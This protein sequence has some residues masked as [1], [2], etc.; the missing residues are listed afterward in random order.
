MKRGDQIDIFEDPYTRT[1]R[2]GT[3]KLIRRIDTDVDGSEW[4]E[5]RFPPEM[6]TYRRRIVPPELLAVSAAPDSSSYA[7]ETPSDYEQDY[8]SAFQDLLDP[9]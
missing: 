6:D 9:W 4:W 2:E 5:V 1:K 7:W 8:N 3:A